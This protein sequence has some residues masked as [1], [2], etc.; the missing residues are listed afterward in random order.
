MSS[1]CELEILPVG[2]E[3]AELHPVQAP[4]G[5][6]VWVPPLHGHRGSPQEGINQGVSCIETCYELILQRG[7]Q[8][9]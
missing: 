4:R 9:V 8:P 6:R 1:S 3:E 7:H 5:G 2:A